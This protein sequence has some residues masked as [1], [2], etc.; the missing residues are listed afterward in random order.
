MIRETELGCCLNGLFLIA[1]GGGGG[2]GFKK[3]TLKNMI[4]KQTK[5]FCQKNCT[6]S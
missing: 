4:S 1:G 3:K 5:D 6:N 2:K